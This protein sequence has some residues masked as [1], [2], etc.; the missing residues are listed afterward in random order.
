MDIYPN[1][2]ASSF[3]IRLPRTMYL[4]TKYEVALAEIHYPHSW[5]TFRENEQYYLGFNKGDS[6]T[7]M[8]KIPKGFYR[9]INELIHSIH[10]EIRISLNST[11]EIPIK[12]EYDK[13]T[14]FVTLKVE[15][16]YKVGLSKGLAEILGFE[17]LRKYS[18]DI[19]AQFKAD[20]QSGFYALF[21][22][23]NICEPQ[24]VGDYYVPMLRS[25]PIQ[26][27]D[28]DYIVKVY[29]EPHYVPVNTSKFDVIEVDIKDDTG[30]N[31][32]FYTGKV[33]CKLHFR[34]KAF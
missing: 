9:N 31:V 33:I 8:V 5:S 6:P 4:K 27:Q 23:C 26:G 24:V 17:P 2:T 22:Y 30:E 25:V 16:D 10:T 32:S 20:I 13:I 34:Q 7:T 3:Q 14:R 15:N 11:N 18:E 12:F 19:V 21:V 29:G 28:G 1:N